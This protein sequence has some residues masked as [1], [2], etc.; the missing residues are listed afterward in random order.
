MKTSLTSVFNI[1]RKEIKSNTT[2]TKSLAERE[3]EGGE[4]SV[5]DVIVKSVNDLF[6]LSSIGKYLLNL[7][8]A[9]SVSLNNL[10][11]CHMSINH[12]MIVFNYK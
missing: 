10:W 4:R 3:R 7:L 11:A 8:I 6:L 1:T 12:V 2:S 9:K 5:D